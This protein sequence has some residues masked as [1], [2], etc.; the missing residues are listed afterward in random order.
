MFLKLDVAKAFDSVSWA[1]LLEVMEAMGFGQRW[2]DM[3]AL[4]LASSS[5]R[6]LLNGTPGSPF[7]HMR[8]LRQGDPLSPLLFIIA[9][10]PLQRLLVMATERNILKPLGTRLAR[11][12]ASFYADDAALFINPVQEEV[13]AV[14]AILEMFG[15]TSG[16]KTNLTKLVAYPIACFDSDLQ[17]MLGVVGITQG[18]LPCQYLGLPLGV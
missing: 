9:M 14:K 18:S 7:A 6:I 8:G 3:I 1:Y 16:L 12:Q 5:S 2:R 10:E 15:N 17:Q 13:S 11:F 4:I